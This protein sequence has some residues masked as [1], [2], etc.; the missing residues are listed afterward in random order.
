M[1]QNGGEDNESNKE[2]EFTQTVDLKNFKITNPFFDA[3]SE[4]SNPTVRQSNLKS[5]V[6]YK[7]YFSFG[8]NEP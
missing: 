3:T 5:S 1:N 6:L 7:D 2:N 8:N 4:T